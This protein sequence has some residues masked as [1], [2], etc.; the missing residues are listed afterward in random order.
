MYPAQALSV[1]LIPMPSSEPITSE[2]NY[3]GIAA[4]I[5]LISLALSFYMI[6]LN[7][8]LSVLSLAKSVV[9]KEIEHGTPE[10]SSLVVLG[11]L[12]VS[13]IPPL[14]SYGVSLKELIFW[15]IPLLVLLLDLLALQMMDNVNQEFVGLESSKYKYK[16]A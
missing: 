4:T 5:S 2:T 13:L 9:S 6:L 15:A 1:P 7:S 10:S 14:L 11:N 8:G 16:G 12:I 3:P